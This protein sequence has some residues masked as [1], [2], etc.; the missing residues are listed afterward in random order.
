MDKETVLKY[1]NSNRQYRITPIAMH[2]KDENQVTSHKKFKEIL[3][4]FFT[5]VT[6]GVVHTGAFY[7]LPY[8]LGE[9]GVV[10]YFGSDTRIL[11]YPHYWRTG[12]YRVVDR[13]QDGNFNAV[14]R[15]LKNKN[16]MKVF[17]KHSVK[18]AATRYG[19][20]TLNNTIKNNNSMALYIGNSTSRQNS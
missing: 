2:Y 14:I 4:V 13:N 3:Q 16:K 9:Y 18:F 5:L 6:S 7:K 15:L 19:K 1:L 8:R 12:E 20:I 10:K 17:S 11:D